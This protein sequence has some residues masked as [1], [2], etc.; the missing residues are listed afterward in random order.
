MAHYQFKLPDIG[1]GIAESEVAAWHVAVGDRI[2]E[3]QSLVD[4]LT[5]KAAIEIPSP[6]AGRIATLHAAVG[7]KV[8]VGGPLVT[9]ETDAV[10]S[11][12]AAAVGAVP[13]QEP[14]PGGAMPD[15]MPARSR[16]AADVPAPAP[17]PLPVTVSATATAAA[18]A[19]SADA[20]GYYNERP[21]AAPSVRRR[22]RELGIDLARVRGSGPHGRV[23][24]ADIETAPTTAPAAERV[25][26]DGADRVE[27]VRIIGLRRKIAEA[28]E[29]SALRIPQFTYVEEVDVSDVE[30][31]R[32]HLNAAHG[33][34]R[35]RLTLLPFL[36]R[37]LV[38]AVPEF[39]QVN[40][41]YDDE[42]GIFT[43]HSA[44]HIGIA[45][46]TPNGLVVPVVHHAQRLD[47]WA[48]ATEIA[49]VAD[50]VR[51]GRATRQ[52]LSGSTITISS[53]GR[54]GGLVS[55]PVLNAP[56]VAIVGVNAIV[57]RPVV[58]NGQVAVRKIM[59]LSSSFDH[60]IVD[61]FDAASFIQ[62]VKGLLEVPAT[63]FID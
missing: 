23:L 42:A 56:E 54:L 47:L 24:L 11:P 45:T 55:T 8:A 35:G 1:E 26:H 63:L 18:S 39:P 49:R 53:L 9:I 27:E 32:E 10:E 44:L 4:M 50:A 37:A 61:G 31:L 19:T 12:A 14:A 57:E 58:R 17:A 22:A 40:G 28:M 38:R 21:A 30:A 3:D 52:E 46:Q 16:S 33:T 2:E 5:D 25:R 51:S 29:R 36:M 13:R 48:S 7:D 60:R 6:V 43:R 41:T 34:R 62:R 15:A 20:D 59:N